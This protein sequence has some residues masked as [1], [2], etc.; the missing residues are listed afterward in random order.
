[1][2]TRT[3][4]EFIFSGA[5]DAAKA[6]RIAE[7]M[8][9]VY[10]RNHDHWLLFDDIKPQNNGGWIHYPERYVRFEEIS[11]LTLLWSQYRMEYDSI[12]RSMSHTPDLQD[13]RKAV[14]QIRQEGNRLKFGDC[15]RYACNAEGC[16][17]IENLYFESLF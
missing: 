13:A 12:R 15:T 9:Y 4:I 7:T 10:F 11:D 2:S 3:E 8:I 5:D 1:M 17:Q 16:H 6:R 14:R